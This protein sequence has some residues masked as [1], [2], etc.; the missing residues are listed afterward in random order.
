MINT[1]YST[2]NI[3]Q[4]FGITRETLRH[5]ERLGLLNPRFNPDNGY[6][7]YSYW[8]VSSLIDI[9]KYRSLGFSLSDTKDAIFDM[10]YPQIKESLENHVEIYSNKL[11]QYDLLL[12]KAT[13]DLSYF[14]HAQ[15]HLGEI[16]EMET[17][18]LFYVPYT[19]NPKNPDISAMH[20]A[21]ENLQFF[22]TG[23]VI[24]GENHD[25]DCYVFITEKQYADFLKL[26]DGVVVPKTKAVCQ[27]IDVVGRTPIDETIVDDFREKI[28]KKYSR[29]FDTIYAIL[30]TRF[31]D[32]EKRYHQYFFV[33]SKL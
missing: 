30:V 1:K 20:K 26:Q 14:S 15:D 12:K 32:E 29:S 11:I 8:D 13:R 5:Y 6:R 22:T 33:F 9:L 10:T 28:S 4:I 17:E 25:L 16:M 3:C 27:M 31:Y 21:F 18:E 24:N 2:K 23:L 7:E 19:R